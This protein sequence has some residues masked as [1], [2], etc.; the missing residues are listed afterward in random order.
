MRIDLKK[1]ISE[2]KATFLKEWHE[3]KVM[4]DGAGKH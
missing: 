2:E 4:D 1:Y 3:L